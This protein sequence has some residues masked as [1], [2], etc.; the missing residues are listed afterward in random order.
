MKYLRLY[1]RY[2]RLTH[3]LAP[4]PRVVAGSPAELARLLRATRRALGGRVALLAD[5]NTAA[6]AAEVVDATGGGCAMI[7]P[8][9]PIV[10][11]D[12]EIAERVARTAAEAGSRALVVLGGGTLTDIAKYAAEQSDLEL[13]CMP[14]AASVD[15]Y[16]SARSALRI[17]GYHRT[18]ASRAPSVIL[19]SPPVV[20]SAP[21]ALTF[22]GLGDLVA[23]VIA[24]L[25]WEL[26]ALMTDEAFSLRDAEWCAAVSRHA[27]MRLR[28]EGLRRAAFPALDAL[29]VTGRAMLVFGTSRPAASCEH[30]MAHLWEVVLDAGT[31]DAGAGVPYHGLLVAR[32]AGYVVSAYRWIV[33]RL[34]EGAPPGSSPSGA[35]PHELDRHL[36]EAVPPD[37][38]PF[39]EKMREETRRAALDKAAIDERRSRLAVHRETI[40]TLA[41][42]AITDAERGLE[43]LANAGVEDHLP[44]VPRHWVERSLQWVRYLRGRY[45]MF[46][47]A[48]EMGWEPALLDYLDAD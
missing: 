47:L 5:E 42:R 18:P 21:A 15:A 2:R 11:P 12:I 34:A 9:S 27:L 40:L 16:T 22:A 37:M 29:L 48:F 10:I 35:A 44:Q 39:L 41:D 23:K 8:G 26:G 38:Q 1:P 7:L 28:R 20:E 6:A 25:D 33:D 32:A 45:S 14:T 30:T 31:T 43:A 19:A 46:N 17:S 13:L 4:S 3:R 36:Q 24:R